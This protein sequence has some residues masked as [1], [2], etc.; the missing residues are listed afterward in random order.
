MTVIPQELQQHWT[1]TSTLLSLR[2]EQEYDGAVERLNRLLDEVGTDEQHPLYTLLDTLDTLG[3]LIHAYEEEHHPL[4]ACSGVD[5]LRFLMEEHG[6]TQS[7]LPEIGSQDVV[8]EI[9]RGKR[10]L[11]VR[12]IRALATRFHV[13][14]AVFI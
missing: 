4:P 14:S 8:S 12:Q 10:E 5:I 7:D 3:T 13:S 1:V 11:N 9:L 6:L 2:N